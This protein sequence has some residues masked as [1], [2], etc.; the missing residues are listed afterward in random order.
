[1]SQITIWADAGLVTDLTEDAPARLGS[2]A[3]EIV[4]DTE[5]GDILQARPYD[6]RV[7]YIGAPIP[8]GWLRSAFG[9]KWPEFHVGVIDRACAAWAEGKQAS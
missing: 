5:R 7:G 3:L 2:A 8:L 9:E 4:V 6:R 1:M